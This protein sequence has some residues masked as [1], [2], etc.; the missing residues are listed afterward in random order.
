M[1][2]FVAF[3]LVALFG[4]V[5]IAQADGTY[6]VVRHAEKQDGDNPILTE[7]GVKRAEHI[8]KMLKDEPISRVFSTETYRT[9]MTATPTAADRGVAV[10]L[11]STDDLSGFADMLKSLDGTFLIVAHSS[12][13]PDLASLLSGTKQPKLAETDYEQM[14]KVVIKDGKATLTQFQTSF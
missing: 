13:T 3:I 5:Q 1:K 14:F 6:Y 7:K 11:F 4:M 9:V 12:S 10:E 2:R 8:V